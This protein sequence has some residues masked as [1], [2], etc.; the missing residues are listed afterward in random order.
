LRL[1][2]RSSLLWQ[3]SLSESP[4]FG[5]REPRRSSASTSR[6]KATGRRPPADAGAF[7]QRAREATRHGPDIEEARARPASVGCDALIEAL[8]VIHR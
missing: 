7:P 1:T 6:K 8:A 5:A 4:S 3:P 2:R